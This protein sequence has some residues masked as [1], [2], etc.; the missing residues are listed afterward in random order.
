MSLHESLEKIFRDVFNDES[1]TLEDE[2]S[3]D[4]REDWDSV[5]HL[6]LIF[7]IE[8]A[9]DVSF[10]GSEINKL[11]NVGDLKTL[12]RTKSPECRGS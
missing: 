3:A 6:N 4:D 7:A 10:S 8:E 5:A 9:F 1:L 11:R 2:M 12:I